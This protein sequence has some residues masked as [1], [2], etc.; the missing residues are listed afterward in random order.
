MR[1]PFACQSAML[2]LFLGPQ[3]TAVRIEFYLPMF[4][5]VPP[6]AEVP[7]MSNLSPNIID[8]IG[9]H[10]KNL[11]PTLPYSYGWD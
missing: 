11:S 1:C 10:E 4:L 5:C 6:D 8:M 2:E 7:R 3:K 9:K